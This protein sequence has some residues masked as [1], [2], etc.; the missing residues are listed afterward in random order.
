MSV[1]DWQRLGEIFQQAL[2][3]PASSRDAFLRE[4]C[5]GDADM[6]RAI[7]DLLEADGEVG[8]FL[9]NPLLARPPGESAA[10]DGEGPLPNG[11]QIDKYRLLRKIGEGG[12][13]SVYLAVR[14]EDG[15]RRRV[16][17]KIIR[18][19][20]ESADALRRFR[21]ESQILSSLDHPYIARLYDGGMV[22]EDTPYFAM[23]Y[24]AGVPIDVYC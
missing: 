21:A 16:A 24:V 22:G 1:A 20:M 11:G 9:E 3:Q 12:M 13:S 17:I 19:G 8:E 5:D 6:V 18:Q 2:E 4:A 10:G 7:E 14:D 23:E 15:F